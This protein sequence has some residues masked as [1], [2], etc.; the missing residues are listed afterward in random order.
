MGFFCRPTLLEMPHRVNMLIPLFT[1]LCVKTNKQKK[2]CV[3]WLVWLSGLSTGLWNKG[4]WFDSW[5]G[6]MPGLQARSPVW[7]VQEA[8]DQ[9]FS[10]L[11][12][13]FPLSLKINK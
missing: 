1:E 10:P 9:C 6:H 7:G 8:T 13:S 2:N 12:P 4:C 11:S 3:P 5:S